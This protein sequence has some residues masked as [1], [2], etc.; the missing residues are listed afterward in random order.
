MF[1]REVDVI[2]GNC[3][4]VFGLEVDIGD[5]LVVG[6]EVGDI[7][8]AGEFTISYDAGFQSTGIEV[9]DDTKKLLLEGLV[10]IEGKVYNLVSAL[11][12]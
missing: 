11:N 8:K 4:I 5:V 12:F 2:G 3:A 7:M 9:F 10:A 6:L 1:K